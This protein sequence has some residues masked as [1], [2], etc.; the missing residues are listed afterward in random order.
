MKSAKTI[1]IVAAVV[2]AA[3]SIS[4]PSAE[5][6]DS[7]P[8]RVTPP[9]PPALPAPVIEEEV[10]APRPAARPVRTT[11]TRTPSRR[12]P[13]R[14]DI[15]RRIPPEDPHKNSVILLEAFMV[16]VSLSALASLGV[17]AISQGDDFVTADHIIKLMKTTDAAAIT[18][19]A[20]LALAQANKAKTE[21]TTRK[22]LH[23]DPPN[24]TKT[25]YIDVGTSF[26]A[27]AEIRKEKVFAELEFQYSDIVKADKNA[28]A[29]PQ[30]TERNWGS[31]VC[32][33]PG[34]PAIVGATQDE[35]SAAFLIV[36]ANIKQ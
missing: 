30:I 16:E 1:V 29:I 17:P 28:D 11:T 20:K 35:N 33:N 27:I 36:T 21:S 10:P 34:Q 31:T 6:D 26:T 8:V 25:Q 5:R 23:M 9:R 3:L 7:T 22:G 4:A 2:F 14:P 18:A 24:N 15:V 13:T 12:T 32:L 19:G